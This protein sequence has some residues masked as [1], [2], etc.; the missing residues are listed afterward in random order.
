MK[1]PEHLQEPFTIAVGLLAEALPEKQLVISGGSVLQS[2]W[3]HRTSTD[4]DFFVSGEVFDADGGFTTQIFL[5]RMEFA[6]LLIGDAGG[7]VDVANQNGMHGAMPDGVHFSVGVAHWISPGE[8][9]RPAMDGCEVRVATLRDVFYGKVHGRLLRGRP[10]DGRVPIRDLYDMAVCS[11]HAPEVLDELFK[12][13]SKADAR[14]A[15]ARLRQLPQN[16]HA[17]DP[18][19]LIDPTYAVELYGLPQVVAE[20]VLRRDASV[21]PVAQ[22]TLA[23]SRVASA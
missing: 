1:M 23:H 8:D 15:A 16:W 6:S 14:S 2:L 11:L 12:L 18:E 9:A 17:D 10:Q 5:D 19:R 3:G 21:I 4:L 20:A 22:R 13:L 7:R